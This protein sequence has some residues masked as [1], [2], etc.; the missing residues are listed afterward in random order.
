MHPELIDS[1]WSGAV[2]ADGIIDLCER[3]ATAIRAAEKAGEQRGLQQAA[4][5]AWR[6]RGYPAADAILA[7]IESML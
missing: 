5:V 7:E 3:L 4:Q 6:W 2:H 1:Y